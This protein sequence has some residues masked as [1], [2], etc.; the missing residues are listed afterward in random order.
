MSDTLYSIVLLYLASYTVYIIRCLIYWTVYYCLQVSDNMPKLEFNSS[1]DQATLIYKNFAV[2]L[3]QS[4]S[5]INILLWK[6]TVTV[7]V[8][9]QID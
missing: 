7:L 3:A 1:T 8:Y 9:Y 6:S 4:S 2:L 5:V